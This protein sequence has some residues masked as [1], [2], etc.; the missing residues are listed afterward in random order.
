MGVWGPLIRVLNEWL[1]PQGWKTQAALK[2]WVN[3]DYVWC[4][5]LQCLSLDQF[6]TTTHTAQYFIIMPLHLHYGCVVAQT[7]YLRNKREPE[8]KACKPKTNGTSSGRSSPVPLPFK[9]GMSWIWCIELI[10]CKLGGVFTHFL[11]MP[12]LDSMVMYCAS[13]ICWV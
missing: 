13:D 12:L 8:S 6:S 2:C 11:E 9:S 4:L 3:H 7:N 10:L 5:R 1:L